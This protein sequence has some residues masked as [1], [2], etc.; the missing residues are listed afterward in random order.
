VPGA[1]D[2]DDAASASLADVAEYGPHVCLATRLVLRVAV[3]MRRVRIVTQLRHR[4]GDGLETRT[5]RT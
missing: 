5:V 1:A 4:L 2:D 3:R